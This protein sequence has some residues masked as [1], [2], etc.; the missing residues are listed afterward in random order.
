V[1]DA[2]LADS[3]I[4]YFPRRL[5]MD[6][7]IDDDSID[8]YRRRFI[9]R[10]DEWGKQYVNR[11]GQ[12]RYALQHPGMD[13]KGGRYPYQPVTRQLIHSHLA[14]DVTCGWPA[15]DQHGCGRWICFDSDVANGQLDKL[16][17]FLRSCD[18]QVIREG[19]RL[20]RDGHLWVLFDQPVDAG[21]LII[22]GDAMMQ[23]AGVTGMERFP[24][25]ATGMSQVRGPLGINLK[26]EANGSRG[27]F[28]G[29]PKDI[30]E[31]LLW[32]ADQ[33][34][35]SA[36]SAIANADK[37]LGPNKHVSKSISQSRKNYSVNILDLVDSPK[38]I[39]ANLVTAC[40]LCV[41]EGHDSHGD[42]LSISL[43]GQRFCCLYG[44]P[45][46]VHKGPTIIQALR[47][48]ANPRMPRH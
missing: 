7:K 17:A 9:N 29:P 45:G 8:I 20:G 36:K 41:K 2:S 47:E 42:N 27:W 37:Y 40:P 10:D 38:R 22:L 18:V 4:K 1:T 25:S 19:R 39:G 23:H 12:A 48:E 31:Q 32:L 16:E 43:D 28:D 13:T 35:N 3:D 26:P 46:E 33:R 15:I 5:F 14:G 21:K 6:L 11:D 24:K 34:P 44:G 30:E